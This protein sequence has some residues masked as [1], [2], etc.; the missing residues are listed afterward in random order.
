MELYL[1]RLALD[2]VH[3]EPWC[4]GKEAGTGTGKDAYFSIGAAT[5]GKGKLDPY[6]DLLQGQKLVALTR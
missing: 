5:L 6:L 2:Q 4:K 3:M 1:H